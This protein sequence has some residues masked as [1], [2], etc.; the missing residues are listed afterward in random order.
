[1]IYETFTVTFKA[2]TLTRLERALA[3]AIEEAQRDFEDDDIIQELGELENEIR[4]RLQRIAV[5][6]IQR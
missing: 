2:R 1:V 5:G 6:D 4:A 3:I